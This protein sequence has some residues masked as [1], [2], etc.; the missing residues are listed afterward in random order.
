MMRNGPGHGRC[1]L[2][3]GVILLTVAVSRV[4][5]AAGI[6]WDRQGAFEV[7]L[8]S[9]LN[10]WVNAKASLVINN[11]PA[12]SDLDD[13]DVALWAVTALEG[14]EAQAGHGNQ[15]SEHRFSRHMAHWR[16]HIHNVAQTVQRRVGAD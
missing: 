13:M 2:L 1:V 15:T 5:S 7:C 16:E 14:C 8:E 4:A 11:D 6:N 3:I 9:R 10:D 12:A